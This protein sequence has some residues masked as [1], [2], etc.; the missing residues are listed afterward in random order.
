MNDD[1][2]AAKALAAVQDLSAG[3]RK[4]SSTPSS[5]EGP[6]VGAA[7]DISPCNGRDEIE[8]IAGDYP[9]DVDSQPRR[10]GLR[11]RRS[12]PYPQA[13]NAMKMAW[14]HFNGKD[15]DIP[16]PNSYRCRW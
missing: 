9:Q 1:F 3:S 16:K 6:E 15:A 10:E 4:G 14:L 2:D 7:V 13:Y 8:F 11:H 12:D 5:S